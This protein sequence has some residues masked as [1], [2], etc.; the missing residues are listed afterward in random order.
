M[1]NY[2]SYICLL[3]LAAFSWTGCEVEDPELAPAPTAEQ[4]T[5]TMKPT[6]NPNIITF[7]ST[8]PGFKA[9]WDFGDGATGEG[10]EVTHAYPV[11]GEYTVKLTI[12]T[13]GGSTSST[14]KVTIANTNPTMLN[15]EDYNFLTGGANQLEGKTWVIDKQAGGH[16]GIGPITGTTPEWYQAAPNEKASEGYYDD[17]MTFKLSN[18]LSYTYKNNGTTF[19]NGA[20]AAGIGGV[21]SASDYTVNYVPP[22]NLTWSISEEGTKKFLIISN[23]GFIGYYTGVSKYEILSLTENEMY[24]RSGSGANA[25]H[26]WYQK[27]VRKGY[28]A[29]VVQKPFKVVDLN[30]NFDT[31]G[32]FTWSIEKALFNESYDNP[33]PVGIN[34]SA[35]VARYT[36][37]PGKD[38]EFA[39][40]FIDLGYRIDL[41]KRHVIK[42]KVFVPSYNDYVSMAGAEDWAVKTLQKQVS[43]KLQNSLLGGNAFTTQ[44][45]VI[46]KVTQMDQWVELTFDFSGVSQRTDF[47]K[48]LVQVGGEGH[49]NPG[50]FFLDDFQ[51]MP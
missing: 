25:E 15:R 1:K 36:K 37:A 10:T 48:I 4:V 19:T 17:E 22:A 12:Y 38:N 30:D 21:A 16:L 46:Q 50:I 33:A 35:K 3:F 13:A 9:L 27:L 18:T 40:V 49:F 26:A 34:T 43:V 7:T 29:P 6:S 47:D 8:A 28:T 51:L 11:K 45:E 41:S 2:I 5:F 23:G 20:N 39:N 42:L 14:Q 32:N 44:A 31:P 24:L